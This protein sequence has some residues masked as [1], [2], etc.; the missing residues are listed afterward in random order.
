MKYCDNILRSIDERL[1]ESRR[2]KEIHKAV[3]LL[4]PLFNGFTEG[5]NETTDVFAIMDNVKG[6]FIIVRINGTQ[7]DINVTGETVQSM[8][9]SVVDRVVSKL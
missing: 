6:D 9:R 4:R 2:A 5:R 1:E 8:V 3:Q 7:Y